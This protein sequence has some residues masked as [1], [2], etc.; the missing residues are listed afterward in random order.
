[1]LTAEQAA[2]PD[3]PA[4]GPF[5]L[6]LDLTRDALASSTLSH[7]LLVLGDRWTVAVLL[8]AYLGVRRFDAWQQQ[9]GIPRPTLADRLKKL[10]ALGLLRPRAY[11]DRPA[12]HAYHLTRAGLQ[13]YDHVLMIWTWERRWSTRA[14]VLPARLLHRSCGHACVPH[15]ACTAC[16]ED[17]GMKD[18][19]FA[20]RV[21][22]MLLEQARTAGRTA[23]IAAVDGT[24]QALGMGLGLRV[25]R[26]SLLI[27]TAVVL[28]CRHFDQLE[29]VLG[30]ASSVLARRLGGMVDTG[31]LSTQTDRLDARR[32]VYRLTPASRDLFGY[33]VCFS[34]WASRFHFHTPSS[35]VPTHRACGHLFVG[36]TVCGH[37]RA[38]LK[39]WDVQIEGRDPGS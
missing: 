15:L 22:P 18:L 7:G 20:L 32:V 16:G 13:L 39:P 5:R 30:I 24:R 38:A 4:P 3:T 36:Q 1:M 19:D 25:D 11:Q 37:C 33:I 31:L 2:S 12:R 10:V 6:D 28:G 29:H 14:T 21:N 17:A 34:S 23:R 27:V 35:I 9:L 26:W 8:R